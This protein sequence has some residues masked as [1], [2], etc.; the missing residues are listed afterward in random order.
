MPGGP[1]FETLFFLGSVRCGRR[2]PWTVAGRRRKVVS[3]RRFAVLATSLALTLSL[4]P[5]AAGAPIKSPQ[6]VR[7]QAKC[8]GSPDTVLL[9]HPGI[10]KPIWDISRGVATGGPDYMIKSITDEVFVNG[11]SIGAFTYSFGNR[12]GQGEPITCT[13]HETF[14][15]ASGNAIDVYGVSQLTVH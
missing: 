4:A 15:D 7:V 3:M 9:L 2:W 14:V 13:Y 1:R 5:A 10:G 11:T 12:V 8:E 6:A